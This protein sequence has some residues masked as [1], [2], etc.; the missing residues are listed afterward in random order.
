M[1]RWIFAACAVGVITVISAQGCASTGVGDPCTPDA[2]YT[3]SFPGFS[4]DEVSIESRSFTCLSRLCLV[5]HFQGRVSC[6]FGQIANP[7]GTSPAFVSPTGMDSDPGGAGCFVP[8]T[9]TADGGGAPVLDSLGTCIQNCP[10]TVAVPPQ[11]T[12][13]G[14]GNR[15]TP[16]AVYCSCRCANQANQTNDGANYC[17]CPDGFSCQQL[18]ASISSSTTDLSTGGYCIKTGTTYDK[19]QVI[20]SNT[21]DQTVSGNPANSKLPNYCPQND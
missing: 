15:T 14:A 13:T 12:G 5:N 8:G 1:T 6:A 2:E 3:P 19:N 18:V 4:V 10:V 9:G 20:T 21:C 16:Q 7:S 11:I 17:S